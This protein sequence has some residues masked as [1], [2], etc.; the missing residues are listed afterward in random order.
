MTRLGNA[1]DTPD[2]A[3]P[4][5]PRPAPALERVRAYT[6]PQ[7]DPTLR[8]KLDMNEGPRPPEALAD[9]VRRIAPA[10][11]N[12][13][14]DQ[15]AL[16]A[17]IA[18]RHGVDAGRVV[19][20]AG[21]DDILSRLCQAYA[22]PGRRVIISRPTFAMIP[23]YL[24][25]SG[26]DVSEI[27]WWSGPYPLE[28]TLDAITDDTSLVFVVT[29]NNPTG[30][31]ATEAEL[32]A[33]SRRLAEVGGMLAVDLAYTEYADR[34]LTRTVLGL[35]NAAPLRTLSKAWGLAGLRVGYGLFPSAVAAE[36]RKLGQPFPVTSASAAIASAWLDE[37][38]DHVRRTA[39]RVRHE[40]DRLAALLRAA[41]AEPLAG[42]ANFVLARF[43]A[44]SHAETF[45]AALRARGIAIRRYTAPEE[46]SACVRITCPADHDDFE[47]L[48]MEIK[49]L[50]L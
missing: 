16:E 17:K 44:G 3:D 15:A 42:Q 8:L 26:C 10:G 27:D 4:P 40:R 18:A 46:L 37:G 45:A 1:H 32:R 23:H 31:T 48:A 13:Y 50:S 38:P 29:P 28:R 24:A 21:L 36:L 2:R 20:G 30:L 43:P 9:L 25:L 6:V 49:E 12:T 39:D 7:P 35:P 5:L 14:P 41:G 47:H 34:D 11:V 19:A 33:L 22:A